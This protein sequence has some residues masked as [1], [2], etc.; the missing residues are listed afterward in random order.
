MNTPKILITGVNGLLGAALS[1]VLKDKN[2]NI[3]GLDLPIDISSRKAVEKYLAPKLPF[4]YIL[5]TAAITNVDLCEKNK[6]FCYS[7]NVEGTKNIRDFA[8]DNQAKLIYISTVSV[9]SGREGNYKE[10]DIP[11]PKNFYNLTKLLGERLV[12]EYDLGLVLRINLIGIHPKGSRGINFFEWLVDSIKTNKNIQLFHDV[13]I[14][15]LS[16]WTLAEFIE[17]IIKINP[18]EK[19]L[20][21]ATS[22]TLSKAAIGKLVLKKIKDYKGKVEFVSVD[23]VSS[24][25]ARPKEMWLNTDYTQR[26]LDLKMPTLESEIE[27]ILVNYNSL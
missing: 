2:Y 16:N 26:K 1:Q 18:K 10:T 8:R 20:H 22:N 6:N 21:L 25:A 24:E 14:N 13:M 12:L 7:V 27:K 5:H 11:Y 9:F 15:P 17:K 4:D 3:C 19:I 23:K